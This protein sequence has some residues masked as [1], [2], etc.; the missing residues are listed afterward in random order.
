MSSISRRLES[1]YG[2]MRPAQPIEIQQHTLRILQLKMFVAVRVLHRLDPEYGRHY[3]RVG[4]RPTRG[5]CTLPF[6]KGDIVSA[7]PRIRNRAWC[8]RV[9][10]E[11]QHRGAGDILMSDRLR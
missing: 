7:S 4:I 9:R 6:E 5:R 2:D 10:C 3:S 1:G 8:A 11:R